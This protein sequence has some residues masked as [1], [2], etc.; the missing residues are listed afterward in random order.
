MIGYSTLKIQHKNA[1]LSFIF[2][3]L[4]F[5]NL[6]QANDAGTCTDAVRSGD[7]K[8]ALS[9][10]NQLIIKDKSNRAGY[11][12]K[13]KALAQTGDASGALEAFNQA[14]RLAQTPQEHMTGHT[15]IGDVHSNAGR[16]TEAMASFNETLK[17]SQQT[18]DQRFERIALNKIGD[19]HMRMQQPNEAL[20]VYKTGLK[21]GLNDNERADNYERIAMAYVALK[22]QDKAI[23]FYIKANQ[24]NESTGEVERFADGLLALGNLYTQTQSYIQ[25]ERTLNQLLSL[26]KE[27][28]NQYYEAKTYI[29]LTQLK[30]AAGDAAA[31]DAYHQQA[32]ALAEKIQAD[33]ILQALATH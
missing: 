27:Y 20:A 30:R 24:K 1:L 31:A 9:I 7:F 26:S 2:S 22:E 19:T 15:L 32:K 10:A 29:A 5:A 13:G 33:D 17:L 25:A 12:C 28:S 11:V 23:E 14:E 6:A 4:C 8:T 3:S 16:L 21:M 18:K